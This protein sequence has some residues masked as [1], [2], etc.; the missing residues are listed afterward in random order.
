MKITQIIEDGEPV[1]KDKIDSLCM[2]IPLFIRLIE[3]AREDA[4]ND[5]QLHFMTE[6][7]L[8]LQKE[9]KSP[10][11]MADYETLVPP[12]PKEE[13]PDGSGAPEATLEIEK[14]T[15]SMKVLQNYMSESK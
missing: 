4:T 15:E 1:E 8:K 13:V 14:K 7:A 12:A 2:D 11:T 5:A 10:L 9:G 3:Y 6:N